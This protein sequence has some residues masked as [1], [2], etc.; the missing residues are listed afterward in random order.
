LEGQASM[1]LFTNVLSDLLERQVVDE[2]RF[3]DKFD[4]HLKWNADGSTPGDRSG[5]SLPSTPGA[6]PSFFTALEEQLGLRLEPRRGPVE[7]LTVERAEKP[8]EN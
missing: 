6:D 1:P 5:D 2:S 8:T 4:V 3:G 7:T